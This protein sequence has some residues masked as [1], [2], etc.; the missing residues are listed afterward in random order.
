MSTNLS[1][2][3]ASAW[4][5][6]FGIAPTLKNRAAIISPTTRTDINR[7]M[8]LE[9]PNQLLSLHQT[10]TRRLV[11]VVRH[12]EIHEVAR[13]VGKSGA[14]SPLDN[15]KDFGNNRRT[16]VFEQIR[17]EFCEIRNDRLSTLTR[18]W[19]AKGLNALIT[20]RMSPSGPVPLLRV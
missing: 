5:R 12:R 7:A 6:G 14:T 4:V 11:W 10:I 16:A 8:F 17:A 1:I 15:F 3:S 19:A 9:K 13:S 18:T 20:L 2:P